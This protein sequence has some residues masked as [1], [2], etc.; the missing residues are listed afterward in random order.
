M[1]VGTGAVTCLGRD[2]DATWARLDRRPIGN[3][4]SCLAARSMSTSSTW[5]GWS[6]TSDPGSPTEDP[7]VSQTRRPDRSTWPWPRLARGLGRCRARQARRIVTTQTVWPWRSA[8]PS[9]GWTFYEAEQVKSARRKNLAASPYL[10]PGLLINQMAGQVSQHLGLFG[11]SVAPANACATGG[12]AIAM[13]G[14]FLA[15]RAKPIW[16]S[17]VAPRVPS[18]R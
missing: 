13:G 16:R 1:V 15:S 2:M 10:V 11:P 12:H 9:A 7:A 17:V 14:M 4:A 6:R 18:R 8:R 3:Q 5:P